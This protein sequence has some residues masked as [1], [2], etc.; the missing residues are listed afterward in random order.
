MKFGKKYRFFFGNFDFLTLESASKI[1]LLSKKFIGGRVT[2]KAKWGRV[3]EKNAQK[4]FCL[5]R[6]FYFCEYEYQSH[7]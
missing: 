2:E 4:V 1:D 5:L 3:T 6:K 7:T